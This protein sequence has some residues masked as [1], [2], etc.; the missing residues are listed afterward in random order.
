MLRD[1]SSLA[2]PPICEWTREPIEDGRF[3]YQVKQIL[4]ESAREN[5][6]LRCGL[7]IG[8][9]LASSPKGCDRCANEPF[10]FEGV[11]RLGRYEGL[12]AEVILRMKQ[13]AGYSL[14]ASMAELLCDVRRDELQAIE[15]DAVVP[16]P[17][18]RWTEWR[19]GYNPAHAMAQVIARQLAIPLWPNFI[20]RTRW[21][22]PQHF[23]S[24]TARRTNVKGAFRAL[25][26]RRSSKTIQGSTV[27][28]VDD[29][30]TSGSTASEAAKALRDADVQSVY[31]VVLAKGGQRRF[32]EK[33][34]NPTQEA[35]QG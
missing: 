22:T 28:L 31:A 16:V 29:V 19:R 23:L 11:T 14:C 34:V 8:P 15:A 12:L 6:C 24:G 4:L 5:R 35:V 2:Y 33:I 32:E 25:P 1:L 9:H 7:Q 27:L 26:A 3:A 18:H 20:E 17:H 13:L 21:T 30:L 10:K